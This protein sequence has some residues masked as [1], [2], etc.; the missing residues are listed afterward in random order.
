[1][2]RETIMGYRPWGHRES[3]MTEQ[4]TQIFINIHTHSHTHTHTYISFSISLLPMSV[5]LFYMS[6]YDHL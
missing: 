2:N 1:M 4:L 6:W 5:G 3:D